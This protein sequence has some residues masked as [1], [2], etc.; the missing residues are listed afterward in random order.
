MQITIQGVTSKIHLELSP[1]KS[2]THR[3]ILW[4]QWYKEHAH[5]ISFKFRNATTLSNCLNINYILLIYA[6]PN[7]SR[8][9]EWMTRIPPIVK[10][11][12]SLYSIITK[13]SNTDKRNM[14]QLW[15]EHKSIHQHHVTVSVFS[16]RAYIKSF[17]TPQGASCAKGMNQVLL[18]SWSW[19]FYTYRLNIYRFFKKHLVLALEQSKEC[20]TAIKSETKDQMVANNPN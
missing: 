14:T 17:H 10:D 13:R 2:K 7:F 6:Y 20:F 1:D 3:G 16:L 8:L 9:A 12:Y 18:C 19:L 4:Q 15:L 5:H 11:L